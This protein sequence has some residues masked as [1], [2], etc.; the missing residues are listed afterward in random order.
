MNNDAAQRLLPDQ[1]MT[2]RVPPRQPNSPPRAA[3]RNA[4]YM[5]SLRKVPA[6]PI[7]DAE[8]S[9][10]PLSD[11]PEESKGRSSNTVLRSPASPSRVG[12]LR[13]R[14]VP[15]RAL[16]SAQ[17][18]K[19]NPRVQFGL[20]DWA[21]TPGDR[22][23]RYKDAATQDEEDE[24][25]A[26]AK[27]L[28]YFKDPYQKVVAR[29]YYD[30]D[31]GIP[32]AARTNYAKQIKSQEDPATKLRFDPSPL[33]QRF[34]EFAKLCAGQIGVREGV[35]IN[36]KGFLVFGTHT[37]RDPRPPVNTRG[38][39]TKVNQFLMDYLSR[40]MTAPL[41]AAIQLGL[42]VIQQVG[43]FK[44]RRLTLP[45]LFTAPHVGWFSMY[46]G[47]AIAINKSH[48]NGFQIRVEDRFTIDHKM[49]YARRYFVNLK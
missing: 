23:A 49:A 30:V 25:E 4:A 3:R 44:A 37:R 32:S 29:N 35:L 38:D 17:R 15:R 9:V 33:E 21:S 13:R 47:L 6:R 11:V 28:G 45:E 7:S 40:G 42:D 39:P 14:R 43:S 27:Y 2:S 19:E 24:K 46:V 12:P 34:I 31:F 41:K 16:Y 48:T 1:L 18:Q 20:S 10:R 5:S 22:W 26:V 8:I 36:R